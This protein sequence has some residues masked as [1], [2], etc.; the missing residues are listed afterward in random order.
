MLQ[1]LLISSYTSTLSL[2][3]LIL[4]RKK[5]GKV[6]K[7]SLNGLAKSSISGF[8][9]PFAYY[10]ILFKAYSLLPAQEAQSLNWTW[11]LTLTIF[12]AIFLGQRLSLKSIGAILLAFLGVLVISTHGNLLSFHFSNPIG[13]LLAVGSSVLWAGYWVLNL[14]DERDQYEKL[15]WN[16]AFGSIF[17]TV[18]FLVK[19][20]ELDVFTKA[21]MTSIYIGICEMGIAF[22]FWMKALSLS[23]KNS[24]VG[25]LAY[26]TPFLS[27]IF[28]YFILGESIS[29]SSVTGLCLI[30]GGILIQFVIGREKDKVF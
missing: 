4:V 30:M 20:V 8:I 24:D 5:I 7:P 27:L 23:S 10:L 13:D 18:L 25:I 14:K 29:L 17:I 15:F 21:G 3:L 1:V 12:S 19:Q 11:P 6:F 16:F 28:I 2:L 22:V 26:L 9:N